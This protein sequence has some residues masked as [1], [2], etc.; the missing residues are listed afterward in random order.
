MNLQV[1]RD[2]VN[3]IHIFKLIGE[4]D[5]FTAPTLKERLNEVNQGSQLTIQLDLSEVDYMDST[6]LGIFVGLYKELK[7]VDGKLLIVGLNRR[8]ERLF[9]I[10]GLH[11]IID[12]QQ[13]ESGDEDATV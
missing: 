5:A 1:E 12:I 9:T 3:E 6:G 2:Q 8:L 13:K 10:T 7:A 4:I 11:E